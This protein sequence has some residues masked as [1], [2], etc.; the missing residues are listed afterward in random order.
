MK[1][2]DIYQE[3]ADRLNLYPIGVPKTK[4]LIEILKNRWEPE[5]ASIGIKLPTVLEEF[6]AI[7]E[8]YDL[9]EKEL[10]AKLE[11]LT[12]KGL[13]FRFLAVSCG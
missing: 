9:D 7:A 10:K 2:D 8:H 11:K 13:V 5:E 12:N 6:S 3:L 1:I 4:E